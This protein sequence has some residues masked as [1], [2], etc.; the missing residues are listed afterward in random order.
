MTSWH[1]SVWRSWSTFWI[2]LTDPMIPSP[3]RKRATAYI[4]LR[5]FSHVGFGVS[6]IQMILHQVHPWQKRY[7]NPECTVN[8]PCRDLFITPLLSW[9]HAAAPQNRFWGFI[10]GL[11]NNRK[12]PF[13]S[14]LEVHQ[15]SRIFCTH[16]QHG[17]F[18]KYRYP[19]IIHLL[20][21]FH[22]INHPAIR[23]TPHFRVPSQSIPSC[24]LEEAMMC[25]SSDNLVPCGL[26]WIDI[27]FLVWELW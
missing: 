16:S 25:A 14:Y 6:N 17:G 22:E 24:K 23:G 13:T 3:M 7:C 8:H 9:G 26:W 12:D 2:V 21:D 4:L 19:Q 10:P 11:A 18:L 15:G 20:G 1:H 5:T 27:P